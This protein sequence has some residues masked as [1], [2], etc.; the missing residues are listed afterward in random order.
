MS[1]VNNLKQIGLGFSM[2][3]SDYQEFFPYGDDSSDD[4]WMIHIGVYA[5]NCKIED[6]RTRRAHVNAGKD[7]E[8]IKIFVCPANQLKTWNDMN[9][10]MWRY[11]GNYVVNQNMCRI[12]TL[13]GCKLSEIKRP[14]TNGLS[15]DGNG[16][17]Q[18]SCLTGAYNGITF[19]KATNVT[20]RPHNLTTNILFV[21]GHVLSG[22]RQNPT[23]PMAINAENYL[24]E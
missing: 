10:G 7:F 3:F 9:P 21:D 5:M 12:M 20:G 19:G 17:Y 13:A 4:S 6:I 1:C 11:I 18:N 8:K 2:Y 23:L 22:A 15:W 16:P 24:I 14:S